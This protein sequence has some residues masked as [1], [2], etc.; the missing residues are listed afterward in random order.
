MHAAI[1][2]ACVARVMCMSGLSCGTPGHLLRQNG[3]L[4]SCREVCETRSDCI[5]YTAAVSQLSHTYLLRI[6]SGGASLSYLRARKHS[7]HA[8]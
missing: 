1:R 6:N 7:V 5:E 4:V 8:P 3:A 2:Y